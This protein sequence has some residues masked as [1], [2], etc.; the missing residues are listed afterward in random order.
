M[1]S[2]VSNVNN[3]STTKTPRS[4][5][6]HLWSVNQV[7]K[8][9]ESFYVMVNITV[10]EWRAI[11][12]LLTFF[13]IYLFSYFSKIKC[14]NLWTM[15]KQGYYF[16]AKLLAIQAAPTCPRT[17]DLLHNN[18]SH[19]PLRHLAIVTIA[20]YSLEAIFET[21]CYYWKNSLDVVLNQWFSRQPTHWLMS[22]HCPNCFHWMMRI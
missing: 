5:Q 17:T 3:V 11:L 1:C 7:N 14:M 18:R 16:L 10:A 12:C 6:E 20:T 8:L 4:P 13:F 9:L 22:Y 2:L 15:S 19:L 21:M